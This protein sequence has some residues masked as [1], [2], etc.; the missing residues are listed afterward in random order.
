MNTDPYDYDDD[1]YDDCGRSD[2]WDDYDDFDDGGSFSC[3]GICEECPAY[4]RGDC[5]L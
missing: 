4:H 2:D 1:I 5:P 3:H